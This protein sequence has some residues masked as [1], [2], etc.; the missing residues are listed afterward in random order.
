LSALPQRKSWIRPWDGP[1]QCRNFR[2]LLL[3]RPPISSSSSS[4]SS[5]SIFISAI[6]Q[7]L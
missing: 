5:S 7:N 4:S 3:P 6:K 2:F 1:A